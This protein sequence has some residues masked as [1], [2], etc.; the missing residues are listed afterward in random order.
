MH[1]SKNCLDKFVAHFGP[2]FPSVKGAQSGYFELFWPSTKLL[3]NWRKPENNTLQKNKNTKEEPGRLRMEKNDTDYKQRNWW[4]GAK[5]FK[6]IDHF[7]VLL[8]L[9]FKA[10]LSAKPF[11]SGWKWL[12]FAWKRNCIQNSFSFERFRTYARF[13]TEAQENSEMAY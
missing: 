9:C 2:F 4:T 3:V 10:S 5:L 12:W 8:C 7:R 1:I 11:L 13:E 6:P